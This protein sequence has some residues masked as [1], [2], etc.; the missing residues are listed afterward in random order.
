VSRAGRRALGSKRRL[1]REA[2][3]DVTRIVELSEEGYSP[4]VI[5]SSVGLSEE[6]VREVLKHAE[7]V[8][9]EGA[10]ADA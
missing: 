5:A 6:F 7:A 2:H 8:R 10:V 9:G 3:R 1:K 4:R